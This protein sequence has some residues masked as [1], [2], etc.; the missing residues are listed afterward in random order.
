MASTVQ[1]SS[2]VEHLA[3][4]SKHNGG[5]RVV[6]VGAGFGGLAAAALLAKDGHEVTVIER[7]DQVGGRAGSFSRDGFN[8]DT[9]PTWYL[10]PD[11]FDAFFEQF[12]RRTEDFYRLQRLNPSYRVFFDDGSVVDISSD[13]EEVYMLFDGLERDGG[14]KLREFLRK[15][16]ELYGSIRKTLYLDL[17][18][19]FSI[20][21]RE[22][23]SQGIKVNIFE[24][25]DSYVRRHF[26]SDKARKLLLYSIGFIGTPPSKA[27]SFYAILNYVKLVQGVY[28]PEGGIRRVVGAVYELAREHGVEFL[29]GRE[30]NRLEVSNGKIRR[31]HADGFSLEPDVVV[32]N[33]DYAHVETK[34]LEPRYR[35][36]DSNYWRTRTFTPSALIAFIG[37]NGKLESLVNHNVVLERDWSEN[38]SQ[39]FN[40][41]MIRWPEY[42]SYYVHVPSKN[43]S[44]AAPAEGEAVFILIPIPTGLEDND[45]ER[46]RLY[47]NVLRDLERKTGEEIE[48]KVVLKRLFSIRD[49]VDRFNSFRGSALGLAHTLRQ[50]AF[51][52][53]RHRSSKVK[54]LY[55]TGQYT[56]PGIGL[57]MV[58]ISAEIVRRKIAK[59]MVK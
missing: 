35:T 38:F 51:W 1:T 34:L 29:F 13:L 19:P 6:V 28:Y 12:G 8:F 48:E 24:S 23:L 31:I 56:H 44:S 49:F 11:V 22:V 15:C 53:P 36:Y 47:T 59:E 10:M 3:G 9:G 16:E 57:P 18:S 33:A 25:V 7:N 5:L 43:D 46:E 45:A 21:N 54:N 20:F 2:T 50:T 4:E 30:V 42:T 41:K 39:I 52:R 58:L 40:P 27:P 14:A 26:T 37:L 32:M 55:Y 17:D